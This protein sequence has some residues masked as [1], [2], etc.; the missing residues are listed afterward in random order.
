MSAE[1]KRSGFIRVNFNG[2]AAIVSV[3]RIISAA[4]ME[5]HKKT[6]IVCDEE[7]HVH[8][9]ETPEEILNLIEEVES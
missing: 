9:D 8:C 5:E 4:W 3:A 1:K 6:K 7:T 2:V